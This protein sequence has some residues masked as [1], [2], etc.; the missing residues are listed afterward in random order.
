MC[1]YICIYIYITC[2]YIYRY[3]YQ[4]MYIY[5]YIYI[6]YTCIRVCN[7]NFRHSA[8]RVGCDPACQSCFRTFALR[9]LLTTDIRALL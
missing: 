6:V 3:I 4:Y 7:Q 2:I 9:L 5:I 8:L 1:I